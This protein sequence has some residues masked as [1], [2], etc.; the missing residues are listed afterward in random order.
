MVLLKAKARNK[1]AAS[2]TDRRREKLWETWKRAKRMPPDSWKTLQTHLAPKAI[3]ILNT[4]TV[5]LKVGV[6]AL[7][8]RVRMR[9]LGNG[10]DTCHIDIETF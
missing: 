9:L 5:Q 2:A 8:V 7:D 4:L 6:V 1:H 3:R 10:K